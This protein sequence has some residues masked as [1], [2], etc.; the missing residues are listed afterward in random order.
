MKDITSKGQIISKYYDKQNDKTYLSS[1]IDDYICRL[2][3]ND[4]A[5]IIERD[6]YMKE[7]TCLFNI[8][9]RDIIKFDYINDQHHKKS[10]IKEV[11]ENFIGMLLFTIFGAGFFTT[12][13]SKKSDIL[14]ITF[15]DSNKKEIN[16]IF[17][18]LEFGEAGLTKKYKQLTYND[19]LSYY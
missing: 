15:Y 5:L 16:L 1:E 8:P 4:E 11:C 12:R 13:G 3:L 17:N 2:T 9:I 18:M 7:I 10:T 19:E 14:I 6:E